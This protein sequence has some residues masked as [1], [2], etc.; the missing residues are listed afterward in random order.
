MQPALEAALSELVLGAE[1][2]PS[3]SAAVEAWLARHEISADDA[4]ALREGELERLLVY[5]RLVRATLRDAVE[6]AIPRTMAR[7]GPLFD[8]LFARFLAERGPRSHY[9]RDV[10]TE[11]IDY[12]QEV[13]TGDARVPGFVPDLMRLEAL[14]I[15]IAA[16]PP[17]GAPRE[18]AELDLD[19]GL[20]FAEALRLVR[21][22]HAV[23]ELSEELADRNPA[24]AGATQLLVY[25]S[26]DHIVRYLELSPLAADILEAL[27]AGA[28][29]RESLFSA[30]DRQK[31]AL[32]DAILTG[33]A[34]LLADL[35]QRGAL[36]GPSAT[37]PRNSSSPTDPSSL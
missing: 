17:L 6:L 1:L 13:L 22:R 10:T 12:A 37:P 36:L 5:R 27:L 35:S 15:E 32:S 4:T 33:T 3:D 30:A 26:P 20:H 25:R 34:E 21:F 7:L 23:H 28:S 14:Q 18:F 19:R 8:E 9:L 29:L 2:E 16:A 31:L 24:R 11:F